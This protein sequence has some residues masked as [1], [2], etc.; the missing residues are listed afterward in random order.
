MSAARR[1][2]SFAT[3]L[4]LKNDAA[5]DDD[6]FICDVELGDAAGDLSADEGFELGCVARAAAACGHEGADADIHAEAALDDGGNSAGDGDFFGEGAL[7][8]RPVAG[9]RD[10]MAR[11]LVVA[12]F[13]A[14]GDGDGKCVAGLDAFGVV[15]EDRTRQNAFNLVA[16]IE[17]NLI[18]GKR[19]DRALKL[20]AFGAMR[21]RALECR[22]CVGKR[23]LTVQV[24]VFDWR[25]GSGFVEHRSLGVGGCRG[26][27]VQA[28]GL[29][30]GSAG[31]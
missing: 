26:L 13:V 7:E 29:G 5:I 2:A 11:E 6:I 22:E 8:S 4:L 12:L 1:P 3:G 10:T 15:G 25:A 28:L 23:G 19:D 14:A 20:F 21:V 9:L 24:L 16:D 27:T 31:R 17:D 18:G 30:L